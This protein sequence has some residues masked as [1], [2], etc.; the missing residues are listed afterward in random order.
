[1]KGQSTWFSSPYNRGLGLRELYEIKVEK[2]GDYH[3]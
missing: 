2:A 1:M 3:C